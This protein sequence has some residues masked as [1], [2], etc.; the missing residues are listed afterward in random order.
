MLPSTVALGLGLILDLVLVLPT[1]LAQS[2]CSFA[3][4]GTT[5]TGSGAC[6]CF[7]SQE[8][9]GWIVDC[10]G[11]SLTSV[12]SG[13]PAETAYLYLRENSITELPSSSFEGISSLETLHIQ[14]NGLRSDLI[15]DG[16]FSNLTNLKSLDLSG[17]RIVL[18]ANMIQHLLP[19]TRLQTLTL[20]NNNINTIDSSAVEIFDRLETL[21]LTS[22]AFVCDCELSWF[23]NWLLNTVHINH[24]INGATCS[25]PPQYQREDIDT[26]EFCPSSVCVSCNGGSNVEC[27][28]QSNSIQTCSSSQGACFNEIRVSN[29]VYSIQKSCKQ[30]R[31]CLN[32]VSSNVR[33]CNEGTTNSVCR[34]CCLGDLCNSPA[35]GVLAGY[36]IPGFP[37]DPSLV[38]ET[39]TPAPVKST[40]AVTTAVSTSS[41]RSTSTFVLSH[42]LQ[43]LQ[44]ASTDRTLT[45]NN[46]NTIDSS[47]VEIFDRLETLDLTSNA[48]VCDCE[49]S[50]F[51]NWLLN[52]VHINHQINGATCSSPP[53]Y[54]RE[55]ID[56]A[57]FCPSSVC[58]SCNGGSNV[59][60]NSQS[61]SIQTCS[62]SQGACFNEIRV[63]NGVYSIQ[64]SCKQLRA[65]L[66][67]VNS[68][69]RQ[70]NDGTTNSVCRTCCLGDLCNSPASGVLAGYTIPGFPRDPSLVVETTTP[71][72][73]KS[74]A[75]ETT[76]VS[77]T[78]TGSTNN[79][80]SVT[81]HSDKTTSTSPT[82]TSLPET[83]SNIASKTHIVGTTMHATTTKS[84][85]LV[86]AESPP[87]STVSQKQTP[88]GKT[89]PTS[90]TTATVSESHT[91]VVTSFYPATGD[92]VM[93]TLE[94]TQTP[95]VNKTPVAQTTTFQKTPTS[96]TLTPVVTRLSLSS[97]DSQQTTPEQTETPLISK[98]PVMQT[99]S[100]Q[101]TS[102]LN[103]LTP[104]VSSVS[105]A[106]EETT[107][108][109]AQTQAKTTHFPRTPISSTPKPL[110]TRVSPT[111]LDSVKSTL[112]QTPYVSTTPFPSVGTTDIPSSQK[113]VSSTLVTVTTIPQTTTYPPDMSTKT[114][115]DHFPNTESI[116][117]ISFPSSQSTSFTASL[118]T[119]TTTPAITTSESSTT[120][121][122]THTTSS[123]KATTIPT[124]ESPTTASSPI[125]TDTD[126]FKS[127]TLVSLHSSS[128]ARAT[129]DTTTP[130]I[131]T[132]E[133]STTSISTHTT[134]SKKATTIPTM[135]S[136]TT[137]SSPIATDTDA[138]KSTTLVSLHSST[139]VRATTLPS[140]TTSTTSAITKSLSTSSLVLDTSLPISLSTTSQ[141]DITNFPLGTKMT[142]P[143]STQES[144]TPQST[145]DITATTGT[146]Q[147]INPDSTLT[148]SDKERITQT[149]KSSTLTTTT[150]KG[151]TTS[152]AQ[153]STDFTA[154]FNSSPWTLATSQTSQST[155]EISDTTIPTTSSYAQSTSSPSLT[156]ETSELTSLGKTYTTL[157]S[158]STSTSLRT[159]MSSPSTMSNDAHTLVSRLPSNPT[160]NSITHTIITGSSSSP[161]RTASKNTTSTSAPTYSSTFMNTG[162]PLSPRTT[163]MPKST[164]PTTL[165]SVSTTPSTSVG[166]TS[167]D[168]TSQSSTA[169]TNAVT[170]STSNP[171]AASTASVS[172]DQDSNSASVTTSPTPGSYS[173]SYT[174]STERPTTT[175]VS[176]PHCPE[177]TFSGEFGTITWQRTPGSATAGVICPY[178][179]NNPRFSA[180][181]RFCRMT[182][183]GARWDDPNITSCA[184]SSQVL[185]RLSQMNIT[186]DNAQSVSEDLK[187]V[188]S[189]ST[190]LSASD[191]NFAVDVLENLARSINEYNNT[192][193]IENAFIVIN[194][195]AGAPMDSLVAGQQDSDSVTRIIH[196]VD[197]FALHVEF[198]GD[199]FEV[200]TERLDVVVIKMN[201]EMNNGLTFRSVVDENG[202]SMAQLSY[203]TTSPDSTLEDPASLELPGSLFETH[204][205]E[206]DRAQF[207]LYKDVVFFEVIT[208]ASEKTTAPTNPFT[209]TD[210]D[211]IARDALNSLVISASL[212]DLKITGLRDPVKTS[213]VHQRPERAENPSCVFWDFTAADGKG[214][215][216]T[217]G[218]IATQTS[219][220][221]TQCECDHLTN[222]AILMDI[223]G[224][225][226]TYDG[227][228]LLA[229]SIITFAG[230]TLSILGLII[231]F[232]S[233]IMIRIFKKA[234]NRKRQLRSDRRT[235]VLL[236]LVAA[237]TFMNIFF[238]TDAV[239]TEF[240]NPGEVAC[241]LLG[242]LLHY[243]LLT[244]IAWMALEA[245]HMYLAL[246]KVF[247]SY[248]SHLMKKMCLVGW[249][250]PAVIVGVVLGV[251]LDHYDFYN[252][253]CWLRVG[254]IPFYATFIAPSLAVILFNFIIFFLVTHQ[255]CSLRRR[256][257]S[258]SS[259]QFDV[260]A[261]LRAS[262]SITVLLGLTWGL[263]IF[264]IGG[265]SL[266]FSYLFAI[267]NSFQGFCI[268]VFH[269]LLKEEV[270]LGWRKVFCPQCL[271]LEEMTKSSSGQNF[272]SSNKQAQLQKRITLEYQ[273]ESNGKH[274]QS[275]TT[276][277]HPEHEVPR[278]NP[279]ASNSEFYQ[280]SRI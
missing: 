67:Q 255:L 252:E 85:P 161:E 94:Q 259:E 245:W 50:W 79:Y 20:T 106:T 73:V 109:Q 14:N 147:A 107:S 195:L 166:S 191:V 45:N 72:P 71:A 216:S 5:P 234:V 203:N 141:S 134:S 2:A 226:T 19:L 269:C 239:I 175:T 84:S 275:N 117:T 272:S 265:A 22:N 150:E 62:S 40:A 246:V 213:F 178:G 28:S 129:T 110:I 42:V 158:D 274:H 231:T 39:T 167:S 199:T 182:R 103:T 18:S 6:N 230:C 128:S 118:A 227:D 133:S 165:K 172:T 34:T 35:S 155:K 238:L 49:L 153:T 137:A 185:R 26:A 267:F 121:I 223:Y 237:L 96:D 190:N 104:S 114:S 81:D 75:A 82:T 151:T 10:S 122:S 29:G 263:G 183:A 52:T 92:L 37:R 188:T 177:E 208:E 97:V 88:S 111:T 1:V 55:D 53:Q 115:T 164:R 170:S 205:G 46:I 98:T 193:V 251:D 233:Y 15:E 261:Q 162:T 125:T 60:C 200:V 3:Q 244:S 44:S 116:S 61:N 197:E 31:A 43:P 242:A 196:L 240:G 159:K 204:R 102:T 123:K 119:D 64:K 57:E 77:T 138:F 254:G 248:T 278:F 260:S 168:P 48:F 36:T 74:T 220:D 105:I 100:F 41:T 112:E 198:I 132:S 262:L 126:A 214:S 87:D 142:S 127:T 258:A 221:R 58:I 113:T 192:E 63:S 16:T 139:S 152:D 148:T 184:T 210:D 9:K 253:F 264:M 143:D 30:L 93:S 140:E 228:H 101:K 23:R 236:N 17:N 66:N 8:P 174:T 280:D 189:A 11:L 4:D 27:N 13:L 241:K 154:T 163:S 156:S 21:D 180:A 145:L 32:Q 224:T 279:F 78:P 95:L 136:P 144:D 89:T 25:S 120:S 211:I 80:T 176:M 130:A 247:D 83:T 68:N 207:V 235:R 47:A 90:Q 229:L 70:C 202:N 173:T 149:P 187:T 51:R 86:T 250:L 266:V 243:G 69:V 212:G 215:W 108:K 277:F 209:S 7:E 218:C 217:E 76:A 206:T 91:Q 54:Q 131:T 268:F 135:K 65:C 276:H 157:Y 146:T 256:S 219:E 12:P 257:V 222:F 59:E 171:Q 160:S 33:Q 186:A 124:M 273:V 169:T 271:T 225:T 38:V 99:T 232:F 270:R 24:Q 194:N 56:T 249:G 201:P 181:T 179:G